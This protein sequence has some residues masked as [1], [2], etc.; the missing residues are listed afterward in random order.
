MLSSIGL[1]GFLKNLFKKTFWHP[2][3]CCLP[4][5]RRKHTS[6]TWCNGFG[7]RY[8][9]LPSC[10][11]QRQHCEG[12]ITSISQSVCSSGAHRLPLSA[13]LAAYSTAWWTAPRQSSGRFQWLA[14]QHSSFWA[15]FASPVPPPLAVSSHTAILLRTGAAKHSFAHC[16]ACPSG[17][18]CLLS[19]PKAPN[20]PTSPSRRSIQSKVKLFTQSRVRP[21]V[22]PSMYS[23]SRRQTIQ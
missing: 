15:T 1:N 9:P 19:R 14:Y 20:G 21:N 12:G 2:P 10:I 17:V 5:V 6:Q 11:R 18:Q 16:S 4:L 3:L 13:W 7:T 22:R 8:L 23:P